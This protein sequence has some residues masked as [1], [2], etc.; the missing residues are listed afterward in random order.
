M[1]RRF[2]LINGNNDRYLLNDVNNHFGY[3]P[4]GL[5]VS[6][7]NNYLTGNGNFIIDST[8][9]NQNEFSI[10]ILF[11]PNSK[12]SPYLRFQEFI[13]FLN[14]LPIKIEYS[15]DV[16]VWTRDIVLN[17]IPK[18]E[19]NEWNTIDEVVTFE[20][21]TP[22]Y[23]WEEGQKSNYKFNQPDDGKIYTYEINGEFCYTYAPVNLEAS[24]YA[25]DNIGY[26]YEE[27]TTLST[28]ET[29]FNLRNDSVLLGAYNSTPLEVIVYGG[30]NGL[31]SPVGWE[32]YQGVE[33]IQSDNFFVEIPPY[34]KL[35]VSSDPSNQIANI[36][37]DTGQVV[38][39]YQHQDLTKTN[40]VTVPVGDYTLRVTAK[41]H[42]IAYRLKKERLIV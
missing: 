11:Q 39:V 14:I 25:N 12:G 16:G 8:T 38:N 32:L 24:S 30:S 29:F 13:H 21:L 6:F 33:L 42:D 15:T 31:T 9:A 28:A 37:Y 35:V 34:S 26:V 18:T 41:A 10:N 36:V 22:W 40:Y 23:R 7:S 3:D 2:T 20:C 17:E 5:G 1:I 19:I 27:D 4:E